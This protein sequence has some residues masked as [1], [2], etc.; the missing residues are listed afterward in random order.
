MWITPEYNHTAR[1]KY[2]T[3]KDL[4]H[5]YVYRYVVDNLLATLWK[6][7]DL[8]T[9]NSTTKPIHVTYEQSYPPPTYRGYTG[10]KNPRRS[11]PRRS[12]NARSARP[13][14]ARDEVATREAPTARR[15][16]INLPT[17]AKWCHRCAMRF[18]FIE[19]INRDAAG[20]PRIASNA[21]S[22]HL[23]STRR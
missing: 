10:K 12:R 11:R 18:F 13:P 9:G 5:N 21:T 15:P 16:C 6:T 14:Q 3:S 19:P 17:L 8:S 22:G 4:H 7:T 1:D 23:F 20:C 2:K